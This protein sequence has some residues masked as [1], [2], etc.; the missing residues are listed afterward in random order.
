[1]CIRD[2]FEGYEDVVRMEEQWLSLEGKISGKVFE[3]VKER[4]A[5]QKENSRQWRDVINSFFYRKS[6]IPDEK[7]RKL[8]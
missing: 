2:S 5:L 1:M 6:M 8:Y 3:R 4:F 7:G